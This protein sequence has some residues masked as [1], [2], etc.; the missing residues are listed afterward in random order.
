MVVVVVGAHVRGARQVL[1]QQ[2]KQRR[3]HARLAARAQPVQRAACLA[4]DLTD[5]PND[6][7]CMHS[8][9]F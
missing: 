1:Q 7:F 2:L 3:Q 6:L 8:A 4:A 5:L 9:L